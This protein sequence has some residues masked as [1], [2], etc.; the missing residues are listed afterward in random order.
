VTNYP[1]E[2]KD[3]RAEAG[4]SYNADADRLV[5]SAEYDNPLQFWVS[6]ARALTDWRTFEHVL[7]EDR[8]TEANGVGEFITDAKG[9]LRGT[10]CLGYLPDSVEDGVDYA[11]ALQ[12]ARDDLLELTRDLRNDEFEMDESEFRGVI[13]REALGL[14]G[15]MTHVLDLAGV[16]VVRE[17]RLPE[18]SRN[19]DADRQETLLESLAIGTAIASRYGHHVAYRQLF[20][21]RE[22]KRRQALTP[23]VD[24]TDPLGEHIGSWSIVGNF[25]NRAKQFADALRDRLSEP[26][27]LVDDAPEFAVPVDVVDEPDRAAYARVARRVLGGKRLRL[28][29]E[30]LSVLEAFAT[31]PYDVADALHELGREGQRRDLRVSEV[32]YAL[33]YLDADRLLRDATPTVRAL[34]KAL[35]DADRPLSQQALAERAGVS[36]TSAWRHLETVQALGLVEE[37]PEGYRLRLAFHTDEERHADVLP[38]FVTDELAAARDVVYGALE[39]LD[40]DDPDVWDVWIDLPADGVPD[41][42]RLESRLPWVGWALPLLRA[43]TA[44]TETE[45]S[46][47]ADADAPASTPVQFGAEI[48]Q[49]SLTTGRQEALA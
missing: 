37:T 29:R 48:E 10:R 21:T 6:T 20:E 39:T 1:V 46:T 24:A 43:L 36:R 16:D 28:T 8:L 11:D 25:G 44:E 12:E 42:S 34:V 49:A 30:T 14:A 35:L 3:D 47:D 4:W 2:P 13:T 23:T 9:Y 45:T 41:V 32:R 5:V 7:D 18:F 15:T 22:E 19:F 38:W 31:T 17:V 40:V 27:D 33:A 26:A